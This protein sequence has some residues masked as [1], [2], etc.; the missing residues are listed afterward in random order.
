MSTTAN[1][2]GR[3]ISCKKNNAE[4]L[5]ACCPGR[6]RMSSKERNPD[7]SY[8]HQWMCLSVAHERC[9]DMRM[10]GKATKSKE[11]KRNKGRD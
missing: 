1:A 6:V 8:K 9:T 11:I 4:K 3:N 5:Y 7:S 2:K 10:D